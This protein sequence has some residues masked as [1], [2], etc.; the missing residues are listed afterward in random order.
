MRMV[1]HSALLVACALHLP[2]RIDAFHFR[3]S[4]IARSCV[5]VQ[6][7]P[8]AMLMTPAPIRSASGQRY[9]ESDDGSPTGSEPWLINLI[10]TFQS[11]VL[12]RI[13]GHLLATTVFAICFSA[14]LVADRESV[15]S[16][17]I[18]QSLLGF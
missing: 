14:L 13:S 12:D 7:Q 10:T 8:I 15:L 5:H 2:Q 3:A 11:K 9:S 18:S 16:P 1:L 17:K 6:R 4:T